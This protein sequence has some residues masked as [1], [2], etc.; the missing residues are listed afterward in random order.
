MV[1]PMYKSCFPARHVA[2]VQHFDASTIVLKNSNSN[3]C[4]PGKSGVKVTGLTIDENV[5][6]DKPLKRSI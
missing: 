4:T 5:D 6:L 1:K 2:V 3:R